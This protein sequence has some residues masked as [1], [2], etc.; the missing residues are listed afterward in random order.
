MPGGDDRGFREPDQSS[1]REGLRQQGGDFACGA[2]DHGNA[3]VMADK[4]NRL[5]IWREGDVVDPAVAIELG[6]D[7]AKGELVTPGA[8]CGLV[9]DTLDPAGEDAGLE[10]G[11][12]GGDEDVVGVPVDAEDGGAD[13]AL[14]ELADPPVVVL[15]KVAHA[16]ALR[17]TRHCELV[18]PRAP[19]DL[20]GCSVDS[21]DGEGGLPLLALLGPHVGTAVLGAGH[22]S[23]GVRSP[24]N[25]GYQLVVLSKNSNE[26]PV[27]T[28]L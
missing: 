9:I 19:L 6:R 22:D 13:G 3:G 12:T 27:V 4:R 23:V 5:T 28:G 8:R 18:P 16:Y 26:V 21:Q 2:G 10:V 24:V 14:D 17:P 11:G 1:E 25:A 15:L 7:L 20:G